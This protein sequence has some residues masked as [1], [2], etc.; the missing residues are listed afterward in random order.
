MTVLSDAYPLPFSYSRHAECVGCGGPRPQIDER[1]AQVTNYFSRPSTAAPNRMT[2]PRFN[3]GKQSPSP[4]VDA[5]LRVPTS[6]VNS[7]PSSPL[8]LSFQHAQAQ[9]AQIQAAT[10]QQLQNAALVA[11][12]TNGRL[13]GGSSGSNGAHPILTPSGRALAVGGKVQNI[14]TDPLT[15]CILYWPDNEPL[16][17]Q[18]QIRPS[19]MINVHVSGGL[20]CWYWFRVVDAFLAYSILRF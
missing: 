19:G 8:H 13:G 10:L 7:L 9:Q 15:P 14:S 6:P 20:C 2:S 17:E 11:A 12:A 1:I 16:P 5:Q 18:G 3:T 4:F